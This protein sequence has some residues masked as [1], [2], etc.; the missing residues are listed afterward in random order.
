M[1]GIKK[2]LAAGLAGLLLTVSVGAEETTWEEIPNANIPAAVIQKEVAEAEGLQVALSLPVKSAILIDQN[3]GTVR[4]EMNADEKLPPASITKIMSLLL[5]MEALDSGKIALTDTVTCSE[6][7]AGFGGS[8]IWLK[9]GEEMTVDDLLKAVAVQ[10]ANDATVCL[11]EYVAG[12]EEA[13][14][15]LMNQKAA[16]LGMKNTHFTNATGLTDTEH[17][18][19]AAD[20]AKL[21]QAAL[22]NTTFRTIFTTEHYTTTATAQH[23]E[24]VSLTSTLLG[25]LDGT[26]LPTGTQIEGGKTGYTAA[27]GLCLASLA[28]VNGKE[29]ILVTLAA[30]GDHG[31]EQYN[32]RDAVHVY[33]KLA[34]KK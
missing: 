30:P 26:E 6:A 7:A 1:K 18:S 12:S 20:M 13:F 25:K 3:T 15:Q 24:G 16:E 33:R 17:Y 22:H 4:Y 14:V 31:T 23:P 9:P 2:L 19:S 29:Y 28:T 21:L 32:I 10:S 8:Q 5:F 27:A 11:A 34:D